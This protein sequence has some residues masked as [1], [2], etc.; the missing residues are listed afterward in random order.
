MTLMGG[1]LCLCETH[2]W[3]YHSIT[4]YVKVYVVNETSWIIV[5]QPVCLGLYSTGTLH[6]TVTQFVSFVSVLWSPRLW[7][8][9]MMSVDTDISKELSD[10]FVRIKGVQW[11]QE[12]YVCIFSG[13]WPV[14]PWEDRRSRTKSRLVRIV[15]NK[16]EK[17]SCY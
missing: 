15:N 12:G 16:C 11:G 4:Y 8:R 6:F 2:W 7:H 9:V 13:R 17:K 1:L 5:C 14:H 10:S 3:Y